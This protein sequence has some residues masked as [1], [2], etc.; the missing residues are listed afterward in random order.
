MCR[1]LGQT[2]EEEIRYV[3]SWEQFIYLFR[4]SKLSA[5]QQHTGALR[6][7]YLRAE[8]FLVL[9]HTQGSHAEVPHHSGLTSLVHR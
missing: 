9:R 5:S 2:A 7:T 8:P 6:A 1:M 3:P 4:S